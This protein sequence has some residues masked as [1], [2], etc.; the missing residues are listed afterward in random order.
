MWTVEE[1]G[2]I[3]FYL[4]FLVF[5]KVKE[6]TKFDGYGQSF[7]LILHQNTYAINFPFSNAL[8]PP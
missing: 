5:W 1:N 4:C 8:F 3:V 2:I 6:I 7:F